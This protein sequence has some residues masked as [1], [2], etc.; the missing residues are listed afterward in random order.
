M[1]FEEEEEDDDDESGSSLEKAAMLLPFWSPEFA[2]YGSYPLLTIDIV[3]LS[4]IFSSSII[5]AV[6]RTQ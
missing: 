6:F 5:V 4:I 2:F 3:V 1:R